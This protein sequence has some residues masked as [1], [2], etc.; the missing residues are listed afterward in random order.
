MATYI[1]D[2]VLLTALANRLGTTPDKLTS[3]SFWP[4]IVADAN[5]SAYQL[6]QST[7]QQRGFLKAQIDSWDRAAEFNRRVGLCHALTEGALT[8]DYNAAVLDRLCMCEDE[9]KTVTIVDETE[10]LT[11]P[12]GKSNIGRGNSNT[13]SDVFSMD[14]RW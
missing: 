7:L 1:D 6:I 4:T 3:E 5:V 10:V 13:A 2:S 14:D 12:S 8:Q 9:L 11:P